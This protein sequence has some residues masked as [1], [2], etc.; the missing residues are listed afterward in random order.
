MTE[1]S[2]ENNKNLQPQS[3]GKFPGTEFDAA[4]KSLSEALRISFII[5]KI[6]MIVLVIVFLASGFRTVG[7][8]EQALV[9]RFGKIR[10]VGENRLLGPGAHWVFPN[11][12]IAECIE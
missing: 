1:Q 11:Q 6:I 2:Y 3:P 5:L 10:G 7:S 8:D 12:E 9:L 4:G